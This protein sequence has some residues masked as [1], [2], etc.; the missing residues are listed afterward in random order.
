MPVG[1]IGFTSSE[2]LHAEV[3]KCSVVLINQTGNPARKNC[4]TTIG[5]VVKTPIQSATG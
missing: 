3:L 2:A 1:E 5:V 4:C